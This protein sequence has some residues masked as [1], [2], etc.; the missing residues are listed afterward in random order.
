MKSFFDGFV[1]S[2]SDVE[3]A[4]IVITNLQQLNG[5][6]VITGKGL[7]VNNDGDRL[8]VPVAIWLSRSDYDQSELFGTYQTIL[9][10]VKRYE[11]HEPSS[12]SLP[13]VAVYV[14]DLEKVGDLA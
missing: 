4:T 8:T 14:D 3:Q 2:K 12:K 9:N 7:F 5:K 1:K 13:Y 10:H 6:T 11:L